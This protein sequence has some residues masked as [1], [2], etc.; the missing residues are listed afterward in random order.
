MVD[1][2]FETTLPDLLFVSWFLDKPPVVFSLLPESTN[3]FASLPLAI[4]LTFI[5]FF[6]MAAFIPFIPFIAFIAFMA[7][8][9]FM[10]FIAFAGNIVG[11]M[12]AK[13]LGR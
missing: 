11:T 7:F 13:K 9:A 2:I 1:F 12:Q 3:A 6:F 5:A 10:A 8:M 4:L